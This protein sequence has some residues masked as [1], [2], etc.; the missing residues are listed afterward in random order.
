MFIVQQFLRISNM[1]HKTHALSLQ[2][3]ISEFV[4]R[5]KKL[6]RC[7]QVFPFSPFTLF[8]HNNKLIAFYDEE[9]HWIKF[10]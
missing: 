2:M 5:N 3:D 4:L 6:K 7:K 10:L 8:V 1:Q 9:N